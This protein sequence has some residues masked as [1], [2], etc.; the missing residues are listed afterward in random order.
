[1]MSSAKFAASLA[2]IF[3]CLLLFSVRITVCMP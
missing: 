3:G 1:M 2:A